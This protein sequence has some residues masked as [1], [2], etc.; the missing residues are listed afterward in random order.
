MTNLSTCSDIG[1]Q[2]DHVSYPQT[3]DAW[4]VLS[5][6]NGDGPLWAVQDINLEPMKPTTESREEDHLLISALFMHPADVSFST[7]SIEL[8]FAFTDSA[9][10]NPFSEHF[11]GQ[12]AKYCAD[13]SSATPTASFLHRFLFIFSTTREARLMRWD[14]GGMIITEP[15]YYTEPVCN[16]TRFLLRCV[17]INRDATTH[18]LPA[19]ATLGR[20]RS[21]D[22]Y[23]T[24]LAVSQADMFPCVEPDSHKKKFLWNYEPSTS[25]LQQTHITL[26]RYLE[27]LLRPEA[28][29]TQGDALEVVLASTEISCGVSWYNQRKLPFQ[30]VVKK[31]IKRQVGNKL[32]EARTA[33]CLANVSLYTMKGM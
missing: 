9:S 21:F 11:R 33:L 7:H 23:I 3:T 29:L 17:A 25:G 27:R 24:L 30:R 28:M 5:V 31:C 20:I 8:A 22:P 13:R 2:T 1:I 18:D 12:L 19:R 10:Y 26:I 14:H 6:G 32:T 16:L 15:F 4:E